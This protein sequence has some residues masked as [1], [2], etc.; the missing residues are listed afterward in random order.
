[1]RLND[2]RRHSLFACAAFTVAALTLAPARAS[3][4]ELIYLVRHAERAD[5]GMSS[6]QPDPSLSDVGKERANRLA[7]MLGSAGIDA[8]VVSEFKRTQETAAPLASALKLTPVTVPANATAALVE[9]LRTKHAKDVVLIVSHS[10]KLPAIIK[11]YGGPDVKID[12]K[13]YGNLFV[14]V[15][16]TH[17]LSRLRF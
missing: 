5:A 8:V 2:L 10:D 14:F 17:T 12:D 16:A 1:M 3:A 15:P 11:A 4:Q 13:D 9:M 6:S 7:T